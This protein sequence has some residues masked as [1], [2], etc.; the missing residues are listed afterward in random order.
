MGAIEVRFEGVL[1]S[2]VQ[3]TASQL[4]GRTRILKINN[5][6]SVSSEGSVFRGKFKIALQY[7]SVD[8]FLS[9]D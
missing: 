9:T 4:I 7:R 5:E 1:K 2:A 3:P 8:T 6:K